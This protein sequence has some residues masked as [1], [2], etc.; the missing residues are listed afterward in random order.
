MPV[1]E[2]GLKAGGKTRH[3]LTLNVGCICS[4]SLTDEDY[5]RSSQSMRG[6][7]AFYG[8]TPAY[9]VTLDY[10]GLGDLQPKL[11]E[12]TKTGAW[13]QLGSL[14]D[15]EVLD[16]LAV[17]GT[18]TECAARL[19]AE[20]G[21]LADRISLTTHNASIEGLGQMAAALRALG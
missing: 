19:Q 11:R 5:E 17:R 21:A 20:Y 16:L 1:I 15:D 9:K 12:M 18:P 4:P 2:E 3:D 7:L 14:I 6:N 13:D 8:S 10:H